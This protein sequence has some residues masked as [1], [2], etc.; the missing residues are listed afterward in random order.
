ME[1]DL[2]HEKPKTRIGDVA[3]ISC[4]RCR[5]RK[6]KCDK[7]QPCA[8]CK[9]AGTHCIIAGAG[10]KQR[11]VARALARRVYFK[12]GANRNLSVRSI[13]ILL[14]GIAYFC[15]PVPKSYVTALEGHA[16]SL[17]LFIQRL[18]GADHARRDE[19]LSGYVGKLG[20]HGDLAAATTAR[21]AGK[22]EV[23]AATTDPDLVL[24]RARA[25]QLRKLRVGNAK[26]FFGGTSLFQIHAPDEQPGLGSTVSVEAGAASVNPDQLPAAVDSPLNQVDLESIS[27][28]IFPYSPHHELCQQLMADFFGT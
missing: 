14:T 7:Q 16:A 10:E 19:L 21:E 28:G 8:G 17:E 20:R 6:I 3:T 26:Q 11:S 5:R 4:E 1:D 24:A 25:G 27:L 22:P 15:R 13:R 9:K 2:P 12:P 18:A 23:A